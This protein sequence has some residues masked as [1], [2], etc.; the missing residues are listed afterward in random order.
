MIF[1]YAAILDD[2]NR[3]DNAGPPSSSWTTPTPYEVAKVSG[4][5]CVPAAPY[6]N[7]AG[8]AWNTSFAANQEVYLTLGTLSADNAQAI[9]LFLRST[10]NANFN[11][12]YVISFEK[13][14]G[15]TTIARLENLV[16]TDL[17][18][19]I[20]FG[21]DLVAGD[22]LGARMQGST[23]TAYINGRSL[24]F[25]T[26]TTFAGSGYLGFSLADGFA[27]TAIDDFGGGAAPVIESVTRRRTEAADSYPGSRPEASTFT[28]RPPLCPNEKAGES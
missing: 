3:T 15:R 22:Q 24:G 23:I 16:Q 9:N 19:A 10:T 14:L 27:Q 5:Q 12:S 21:R 13:A 20:N 2:F 28:T 8:A 4:N 25:R 1:P 26:D 18:A 6:L 7:G 17:G 11:N